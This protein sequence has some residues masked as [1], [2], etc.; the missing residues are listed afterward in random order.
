MITKIRNLL[1][2]LIKDNSQTDSQT[3]TAGSGRTFVI[4]QSNASAVSSVTVAGSALAGA[5]YSYTVA[6]QTVTI[7]VGSVSSGDSV[8][9]YYTYTKY[10]NSELLAYLQSALS[11]MDAFNYSPH[12]ELSTDETELYPIPEWREQNLI[13]IIASILINPEHSEKRLPN[14]TVRYPRTQPKE[15]VI[16]KLIAKFKM[17]KEGVIG[18]VDLTVGDI[19]T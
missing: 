16:E 8:V 15:K 12:Y 18:A 7:A 14:L 17:C 10:S 6:T 19:D 1:R 11:W 2:N 4:D 13:A 9:I 3:Y 5:N